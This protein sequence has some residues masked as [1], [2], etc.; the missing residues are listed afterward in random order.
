MSY[1]LQARGATKAEAR[2]ALAAKFESEVVACQPVHSRDRDAVLANVDGVLAALADDDSKDVV[3]GVNG[4]VSWQSPEPQA[5]V[6]LTTV[7]V[8]ANAALVKR[9]PQ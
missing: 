5:V 7:G 4:Y 3:I 8:S 2:A 6:P 1:S 9:E